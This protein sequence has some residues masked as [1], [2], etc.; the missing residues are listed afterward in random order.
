MRALTKVIL[1]LAFIFY[2]LPHITFSQSPDTLWTRTYGGAGSDVGYSVKQTNDG[3]F[4][5]AGATNSFGAGDYDIYLIKTNQFG[6]TL[7][8]K[9]FGGTG[10]D[11]G[12]EVQQTS[13]G[14]YIVIGSTDSFNNSRDDLYLI[15]TDDNGDTLW[16]KVYGGTWDDAGRSIMED[17]NGNYLATGYTMS[18][19]PG[20]VDVWILKFNEFGDTLWTRRVGGNEVDA[21]ASIKQL[22]NDDYI[23]TGYSIV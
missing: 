8:T 6:D 14:G 1:I 22:E 17:I 2:Y 3:G 18:F 5:I 19:D 12:S 23:I 21:G 16:T 15:K 4:I 13:D 7:W 20:N 10:Q 9:I 11:Y